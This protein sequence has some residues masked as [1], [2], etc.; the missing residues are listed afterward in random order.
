MNAPQHEADVIVYGGTSGGIAAAMQAVRLGKTALIVGPDV[1]LGGLSSSGLGWADTGR[2][3]AIGGI[4]REFYERVAG[5]YADDASWRYQS[6]EDYTQLR[7][8]RHD[9]PEDAMW[10]FEPHV[11]ERTYEDFVDECQ[12]PV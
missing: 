6:H 4:A 5:H 12:I 10:V 8:G 1:H 3:E 9:P 2:K 11:A 7:G